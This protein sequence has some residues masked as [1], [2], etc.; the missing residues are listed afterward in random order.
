MRYDVVNDRCF[1]ISSLGLTSDTERMCFQESLTD[2]LPS[3]VVSSFGSTSTTH[4]FVQLFVFGAV[5]FAVLHKIRTAW[6]LAWYFRFVGHWLH[7]L[8]STA[9]DHCNIYLLCTA[10]F[11][12]A[13]RRVVCCSLQVICRYRL[14]C[15][16]NYSYRSLLS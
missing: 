3:A 13:E 7:I 2:F 6:M 11:L 12:S 4:S 5:V 10:V 16:K 9:S 1:H 15:S 14:C 8:F